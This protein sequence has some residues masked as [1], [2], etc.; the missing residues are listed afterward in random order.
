MF[1]RS[2]LIDSEGAPKKIRHAPPR[3]LHV[4]CKIYLSTNFDL[5]T[6]LWRIVWLCHGV[7]IAEKCEVLIFRWHLLSLW[8]NDKVFLYENTF[9]DK[10]TTIYH[11]Q[12]TYLCVIC[13]SSGV[14][15][16]QFKAVSWYHGNW[17]E[18]GGLKGNLLLHVFCLW[19]A[20]CIVYIGI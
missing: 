9:L 1:F 19:N 14:D 13:R 15:E 16:E 5:K 12:C 2:I 4:F 7:C 18:G 10:H 6:H 8:R 11:V 3:I 17:T 20:V